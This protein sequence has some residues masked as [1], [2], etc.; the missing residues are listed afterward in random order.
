MYL[1][2]ISHQKPKYRNGFRRETNMVIRNPILL[3][4]NGIRKRPKRV[5]QSVNV[6]WV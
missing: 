3:H 6:V 5:L 4:S 2:G 1:E